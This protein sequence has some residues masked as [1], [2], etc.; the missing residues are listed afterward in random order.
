MN[1]FKNTSQTLFCALVLLTFVLSLNTIKCLMDQNNRGAPIVPNVRI[2]Q[3]SSNVQDFFRG[4]LDTIA[5]TLEDFTTDRIPIVYP[6]EALRNPFRKPVQMTRN[7]KSRLLIS[8]IKD[9]IDSFASTQVVTKVTDETLALHSI[10][11]QTGL[12]CGTVDVLKKGF[13]KYQVCNGLQ[14]T[15]GV[16]RKGNGTLDFWFQSLPVI[17]YA[18]NISGTDIPD[19]RLKS[20]R[21][22]SSK[23]NDSVFFDEKTREWITVI[24][25]KN[26][27]HKVKRSKTRPAKRNLIGSLI[28]VGRDFIENP[29]KL[30]LTR[31]PLSFILDLAKDV[32]LKTV[33]KFVFNAIKTISSVSDLKIGDVVNKNT[34]CTNVVVIVDTLKTVCT[35]N[36]QKCNGQ[37]SQTDPLCPPQINKLCQ[38][39]LFGISTTVVVESCKLAAPEFLRDST[40]P[41]ILTTV[42]GPAIN[43]LKGA[44]GLFRNREQSGNKRFGFIPSPNIQSSDIFRFT[45]SQ[46]VCPAVINPLDK[47]L[48][49]VRTGRLLPSACRQVC[50]PTSLLPTPPQFIS[51]INPETNECTPR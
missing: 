41:S 1:V 28:N 42:A 22:F 37:S 10:I 19:R 29:K 9:V 43:L 26:G 25:L 23:E 30:D 46:C 47:I 13:S 4:D 7:T 44:S 5:P 51:F 36:Q 6:E 2:S 31:Q 38:S 34:F 27:S 24:P 21:I 32:D 14:Q 16:M 50:N 45:N 33:Y 48:C 18:E 15:P 20:V 8:E 12:L 17:N 35:E 49:D 3:F 11:T 40:N 39:P